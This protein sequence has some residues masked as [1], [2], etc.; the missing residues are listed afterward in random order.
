MKINWVIQIN[1]G[2]MSDIKN[3][4]ESVKKTN[5]NVLELSHIPFSDEIQDLQLKGPVVVY[6]STSFINTCRKNSVLKYGIFGTEK[7]F[8][9][10]NCVEKYGNLLFNS[11]ESTILTTIGDFEKENLDFISD[12]NLIFTKPQEDTK[13]FNGSVCKI[14][15]F[16]KWCSEAKKSL[17]ANLSSDTKIIVSKPFNINAEWRL[18]IVNN[19]IITSSQY[20]KN[21]KFE[22]KSGAPIE[23]LNF[24]EKV[25]KTYSPAV[26]YVLDICLSGNNY[27][28][29]EVQNINSAGAYA[30]D[31]EKY[32]NSINN[33]LLSNFNN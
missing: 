21:K 23:V 8:S 13:S 10:K 4:V 18:L 28:I 3:Y 17:Y 11:I 26:A 5:S 25:I 19:Q 31:I 20:M 9:Y 22:I 7:D 1:M 12:N 2:S 24:A 32:A 15:D 33:Y 27:Y 29:M 14:D 30:C 6:G 16:K